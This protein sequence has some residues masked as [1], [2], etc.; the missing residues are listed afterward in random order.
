MAA[1]RYPALAWPALLRACRRG[2]MPCARALTQ[3]FGRDRLQYAPAAE[4]LVAACRGGDLP[5]VQWI[6]YE[7][8]PNPRWRGN[9]ALRAAPAHIA[10]WL[11][12]YFKLT[13]EDAAQ[14]RQSRREQAAPARIVEWLRVHFA[15]AE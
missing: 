14:A 8:T 15:P 11:R 13:D 6:A 5:L 2:D 12:E 3:L 4:L 7:W 9:A 1:A 10:A